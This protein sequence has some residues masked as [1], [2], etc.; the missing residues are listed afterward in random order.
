MTGDQKD[1]LDA[2]VDERAG[3][4]ARYGTT[5]A[6]IAARIPAIARKRGRKSARPA[7]TS[8]SGTTKTLARTTLWPTGEGTRSKA[9]LAAAKMRNM[10]ASG[11]PPR[12]RSA[13][14]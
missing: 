10:L 4:I 8:M 14:A 3:I 9:T 5:F 7:A 11:Q 6:A 12:P 13:R 2:A 1:R